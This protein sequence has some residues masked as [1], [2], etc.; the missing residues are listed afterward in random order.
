MVTA[1]KR[2]I[3]V[4]LISAESCKMTKPF[5]LSDA[6]ASQTPSSHRLRLANGSITGM[7]LASLQTG[8]TA[9]APQR[10]I[11]TRQPLTSLS[12]SGSG[13]YTGYGL[14]AGVK[15]SHPTASAQSNSLGGRPMVKSRGRIF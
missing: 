6:E 15:V 10:G 13:N 3:S 5:G 8:R 1:V 14:S 12:P 7:G 9:S 4:S 2:V 11:P